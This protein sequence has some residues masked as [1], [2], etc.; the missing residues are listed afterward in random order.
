MKPSALILLPLV[1]PFVAVETAS[2]KVPDK[3]HRPNDIKSTCYT[4][5]DVFCIHL[6]EPIAFKGDFTYSKGG[7]DDGELEEN[8]R[9]ILY[10]EATIG[11]Y[12]E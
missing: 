5:K 7:S 2:V 1:L 4:D 10:T 9:V 3:T 12:R 11:T 8:G 6:R